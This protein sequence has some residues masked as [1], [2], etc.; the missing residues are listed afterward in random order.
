MNGSKALIDSNVIIDASKGLISIQ[1]IV[2][3]YNNLYTSIISYVETLG[4][5]FADDEE[6]DIIIQIL[7]NVQ[8]VD[9]NKKIADIAIDYRKQKKIKLPDAFVLATAKSINA[10]LITS[11]I[12]DFQNIDISISIVEP[13]KLTI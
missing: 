10:D 8:I 3:E 2:N 4:Y 9:L 13:E 11:D 6:K 5:N 1:K 12:K 7:N